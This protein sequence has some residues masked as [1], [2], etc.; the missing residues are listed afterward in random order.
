MREEG[1]W[2]SKGVRGKGEDRFWLIKL[3]MSHAAVDDW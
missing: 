2:V 1:G 3:A